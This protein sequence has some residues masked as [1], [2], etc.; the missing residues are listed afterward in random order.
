M[1][2]VLNDANIGSF[3]VTHTNN[4]YDG[5]RGIHPG[6]QKHPMAFEVLV[7]AL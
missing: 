6:N 3:S 1:N 2:L 5:A 4:D 7:I